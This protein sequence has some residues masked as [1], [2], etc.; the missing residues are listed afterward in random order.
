MP[1]Q[2]L[3]RWFEK[4]P[5]AGPTPLAKKRSEIRVG[6]PRVLNLWST[7]QF[8]LGFLESLGI[9]AKRIEFSSDSSEDQAREFGKGRGTVD[10]C[11][12]VKNNSGHYGELIFGQRKKIHVLLHPVFI[13]LPS[14]L[15]GHVAAVYA[16]TRDAAAAENIKA[17][18]LREKDV[19]AENG[20]AY[21]NPAVSL[22]E[23]ELMAKQL[24][25]SPLK[26]ALGLDWSEMQPAVDA[27][28]PALHRFQNEMR[29]AR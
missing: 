3:L 19:F 7:H 22:A 18:F 26:E 6:I 2:T 16:C 29:A 24:Y 13:T 4:T 9:D 15:T 25:D 27:G 12:P 14:F 10:C 17:G 23:P 20:I 21:C 5:S 28:Y 11:Y 1:T 8:W